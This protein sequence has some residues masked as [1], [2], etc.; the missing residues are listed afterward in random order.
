MCMAIYK[1]K[2]LT[3][4]ER[5]GCSKAKNLKKI[6]VVCGYVASYSEAF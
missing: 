3:F 6:N 1:K 5:E 2:R 4:L